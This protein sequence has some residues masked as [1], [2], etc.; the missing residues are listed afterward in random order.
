MDHHAFAV[1][2]G[3]LQAT[4]FGAAQAGCV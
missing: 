1:D 2:V 4:Q 3:D